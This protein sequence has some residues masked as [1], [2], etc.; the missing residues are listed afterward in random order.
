MEKRNTA[1]RLSSPPLSSSQKKKKTERKREKNACL[2]NADKISMD[3]LEALFLC[4]PGS[5]EI[6]Q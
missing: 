2:A 4:Q 1:L 6:L 5:Q 3:V